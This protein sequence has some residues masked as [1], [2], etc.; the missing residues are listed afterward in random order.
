MGSIGRRHI[1]N[2]E[3]LR[4]E[5]GI[6]EIRAFDLDGSRVAQAQEDWPRVIG[7]SSLDEAAAGADAIVLCVST[8]HHIS[9]IDHLQ[10]LGEFH[11]YVEKPLSHTLA[12][13]DR[14]LFQ[15]QRRGKAAVVG[16][17]LPN[18]PVLLRAKELLQGGKIGRVLSVRAESGFYLPY[19]HPWEDYRDFY[20]SW[21]TG[22]G[23][24]LL[25]TS[26]EIN[27]LQW[28]LDDTI[29]EV[30]GYMEKVSDLEIT[31]DDLALAM[32]RTQK[33]TIGELHLDLL[34]FDES[35]WAKLIGADGVMQIDLRTNEIR[36]WLKGET[37]WMSEELEVDFD[38]IYRTQMRAFARA[39]QGAGLGEV[40]LIGVDRALET[41]HFIEAVRRSRSH[42]SVI[43]LPLYD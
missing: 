39:C 33:G 32:F 42:G 4:D 27:Y 20:M 16:Y 28:L 24:A 14:F 40:N 30:S 34:Q 3:G 23:G 5:L 17:M 38:E 36:T 29:V 19:W 9:V 21:K 25:D 41:M 18:H 6:S 35:R 15:Q 22:G 31:T 37:G 12:G 7:C 13:C 10:S 2:L 26:H 43:R 11:Y 1:G 8:S